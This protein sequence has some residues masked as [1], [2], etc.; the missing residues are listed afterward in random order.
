MATNLADYLS[1][2]IFVRIYNIANSS[3]IRVYVVGEFVRDFYL[4]R[5][6]NCIEI[7]VEGDAVEFG[8]R[9][10]MH[11]HT[12][13]T[14][15]KNFGVSKIS[16][17]GDE[18]VFS[19]AKR[20]INKPE[21]GKPTYVPGTIKD[22]LRLR[23]FTI[24]AL[25]ISLNSSDFGDQID[26]FEGLKDISQGIIR[27]PLQ[28][29]NAFRYNPLLMLRA[30][31]LASQLSTPERKFQIASGCLDAIWKYADKVDSIAK[32]RVSEEL[33]EILLCDVPSKGIKLLED[34]RI[35]RRIIPALSATKG[36]EKVDGI[37]HADSFPHSLM[38]VDNIAKLEVGQS[39]DTTNSLGIKQGEPNLW[40]RW[41]A[42]LHEIG[43][44]ATKRYVR[45]KGWTFNGYDVVGAKM[46][47][48]V[49]SFLK[50]PL[51]EN[52][53]YVQKLLSLQLRPR[54]LLEKETSE[55][56][57]RRLLFEAGDDIMDLVLLCQANVTT[58]NK[59]KA[60]KELVDLERLKQQLLEVKSKE[61]VRNFKNPISA[62][63]IMELYGLE[64]C[65]TLGVL[66][67]I[68]KNAI[69]NGEIGNTFEAADILLRQ[70]AA[71]MGLT[72][73][74]AA[75]V[76]QESIGTQQNDSEATSDVNSIEDMPE[77]T[78]PSDIE[79]THS[80]LVV[81]TVAQE[82]VQ[83]ELSV[84]TGPLQEE[85]PTP[86]NSRE[87]ADYS[88]IIRAFNECGISKFFLIT[89]EEEFNTIQ[90]GS[91][92]VK[93]SFALY[94]HDFSSEVRKESMFALEVDLRVVTLPGTV[95]TFEELLSKEIP[96]ATEV[97]NIQLLKADYGALCLPPSKRDTSSILSSCVVIVR[98]SIPV[99]YITNYDAMSEEYSSSLPF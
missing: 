32:E 65:N 43:K 19:S 57:Y 16:F 38:V 76:E 13:V 6:N 89:S 71:E 77:D 42:L 47:S 68:I 60:N 87:N 20:G 90:M 3:G 74:S 10:G 26:L 34:L 98:N 95:I 24:N 62:N 78:K 58:V 97:S 12:Y 73:K 39:S 82:E 8:R 94:T 7:V 55:S 11:T 70:K 29:D 28:P 14:Y 50:M 79:D 40:L 15:F 80:S 81:E 27:T 21:G 75:P 84:P 36:V 61:A 30:I 9:M 45:G 96:I 23:D 92:L 91:T 63:Y 67:D 22:D 53:R 49:F 33:N 17:K 44:P 48:N 52:V 72:I 46:I 2:E 18:I 64:P 93:D 99:E 4:S 37:G 54:T 41:A 5:Q 69:L 31:R 85:S 86:H 88:V 66:K 35:L 25:A 51:N 56:A 59:V 83:E 1:K